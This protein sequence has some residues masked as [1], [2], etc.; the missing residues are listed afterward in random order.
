M[1]NCCLQGSGSIG[2]SPF[3]SNNRVTQFTAELIWD[4]FP[5]LKATNLQDKCYSRPTLSYSQL[6]VGLLVPGGGN[7]HPLQYPCL[8]NPGQGQRTPPVHGVTKT[9]TG[10]R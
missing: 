8:E 2:P 7:S 4:I 5:F 3:K 10:L 1:R 9:Q 6:A